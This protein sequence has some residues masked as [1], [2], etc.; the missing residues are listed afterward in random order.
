MPTTSAA[1]ATGARPADYLAQVCG[2]LWPSPASAVLSG[3]S[4]RGRAASRLLVLPSA[5]AP[6]LILPA[7]RRAGSAAVGRYGEPG[8]ARAKLAARAL[9]GALAAGLGPA[10]GGRLVITAPEGADTIETYLAELIGHRVELSMHVGAARAN[11]KPVLQLLTKDGTTVGFAKVGVN[12]LTSALVKAEQAALARLA[13]A[14][15]T[16]LRLPEVLAAGHWNGLD[17]LVLRPLPVW[18]RR[19]PLTSDRLAAA[20][21][22]LSRAV[23]TTTAPLT[24]SDYWGRLRDRL[25]RVDPGDEKSLL[26]GLLDELAERA[27]DT[28]LVYGCWHGDL[29]PWNLASTRDG[30]LVWDWERFAAPAPLGFDAL[31]HQLQAKVADQRAD[32]LGAASGA[33][34][35]SPSLLRP[36]EAPPAQA[37]LTALLYLAELSVRY[38]AD[39]Q[40]EAGARLGAP[41]TWLLP[42][43]QAGVDQ[44]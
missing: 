5:Q 40:A 2:L 30:L 29:T 19:T 20:L 17:V 42:A 23:G 36:F 9:A 24:A 31:H 12:P 1:P 35:A 13:G 21:A 10:L 37:R 7:G 6:R 22:E 15:L 4:G 39:R 27:G 41:G 43:L 33:V 3:R 34:E 11:R 16:R 38:L 18:L 26:G 25:G 44:L 32:P 28:A 8:S 14:S